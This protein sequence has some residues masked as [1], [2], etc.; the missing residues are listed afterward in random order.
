MSPN[1]S[2]YLMFAKIPFKNQIVFGKY[3]SS[4]GRSEPDILCCARVLF[5]F[6]I[7]LFSAKKKVQRPLE[8]QT[9]FIPYKVLSNQVLAIIELH[10][11]IELFLLAF[12]KASLQY[13]CYE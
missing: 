13:F 10:H 3:G 12:S 4:D 8:F 7:I 9:I 2:V 1:V 5:G 11:M 6:L